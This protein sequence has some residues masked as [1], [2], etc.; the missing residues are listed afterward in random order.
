MLRIDE[1]FEH[2]FNQ[3]CVVVTHH[4]NNASPELIGL[5]KLELEE[6]G[7]RPEFIGNQP[8]GLVNLRVSLLR[9]VGIVA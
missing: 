4:F 6:S 3:G 1:K 8:D 7:S 9:S 5:V 2:K